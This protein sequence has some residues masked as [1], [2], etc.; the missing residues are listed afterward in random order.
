[1]K[2]LNEIR[3]GNPALQS[4][5][6]LKF[7]DIGNDQLIAYSKQEGDNVILVVV[8][9]D[10]YRVQSGWLDVHFSGPDVFEIEDLLADRGYAWRQ[11]RNYVELNPHVLPAHVFRVRRP[12]T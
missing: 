4:N 12:L 1:V 10:P 2:K 11:G 6:S 3:K 8:S 9:L 5:W 7:H